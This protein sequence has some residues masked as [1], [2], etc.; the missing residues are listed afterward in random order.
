L[1]VYD[2]YIP[3]LP[4]AGFAERFGCLHWVLKDRM[5]LIETENTLAHNEDDIYRLQQQFVEEGYEGAMVRNLDGAYALA[6]RSPNLQKVKSFLDAEYRIVGYEQAEG[7]DIG[8]V[9]WK[10]VTPAGQ[11]FM[12]RPTGTRE[13]RRAWFEAGQQYIGKMLTVKYQELTDDGIPRFPV[14][15][16]VRDYE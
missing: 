4:D 5:H 6:K 15:I 7:G 1:R 11:E 12:T 14:G 13:Q 16:A 2:C 10:C 9:I 3:T 8:T